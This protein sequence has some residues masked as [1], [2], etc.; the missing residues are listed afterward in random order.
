MESPR[1]WPRS[2]GNSPKSTRL[3]SFMSSEELLRLSAHTVQHRRSLSRQFLAKKEES[4]SPR[5]G[6]RL[7][8]GMKLLY[9]LFPKQEVKVVVTPAESM[10]G[11]KLLRSL[12]RPMKKSILLKRDSH[13]KP[14]EKEDVMSQLRRI[15]N[16]R[17][18]EVLFPP[19]QLSDV[20]RLHAETKGRSR[21]LK[22]LQPATQPTS[23]IESRSPSVSPSLPASPRS[24]AKVTTRPPVPLRVLPKRA[25][26][27]CVR[28]L[29]VDLPQLPFSQHCAYNQEKDFVRTHFRV[30]R[31]DTKDMELERTLL[32]KNKRL[33]SKVIVKSMKKLRLK[34]CRST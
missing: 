32:A 33:D 22:R 15:I 34:D 17:Q 2:P 31:E 8:R 25:N 3:S 19:D 13:I 14:G 21:R 27:T 9:E 6:G 11:S 29:V 23:P 24:P 16:R 5:A 30:L 7:E 26:P 10:E 4:V 20:E 12:A 28:S 18:Q 1:V